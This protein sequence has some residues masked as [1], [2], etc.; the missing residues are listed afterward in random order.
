M[1]TGL[2]VFIGD[3]VLVGRVVGV[4]CGEVGRAEA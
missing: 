2:P 1:L 4:R 3:A